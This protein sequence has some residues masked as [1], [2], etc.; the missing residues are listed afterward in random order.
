MVTN[1]Q[2]AEME[3]FKASIYEFLIKTNVPETEYIRDEDLESLAKILNGMNA[4]INSLDK[5]QD[6]ITYLRD[7]AIKIAAVGLIE[8]R[9]QEEEY[10]S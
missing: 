2:H 9:K 10:G 1:I 4:N 8:L 6:K 3:R 5:D 7:M